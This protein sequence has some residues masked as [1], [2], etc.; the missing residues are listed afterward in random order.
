MMLKEMD[1][2]GYPVYIQ[3]LIPERERG[4]MKIYSFLKD[5]DA[6]Q[7]SLYFSSLMLQ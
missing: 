7:G 2:A 5:D 1:A 4:M 6:G 3:Q